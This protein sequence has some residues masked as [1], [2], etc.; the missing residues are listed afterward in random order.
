[1][2]KE[3]NKIKNPVKLTLY[4][5]HT[6]SGSL[7]LS[8]S[9]LPFSILFQSLLCWIFS[10]SLLMKYTKLHNTTINMFVCIMRDVYYIKLSFIL[11]QRNNWFNPFYSVALFIFSL[12]LFSFVCW[13]GQMKNTHTDNGWL[14]HMDVAV[15]IAPQAC[16]W[17]T[18]S[19]CLLFSS[20]FKCVCAW[21]C[22]MALYVFCA[23]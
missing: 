11:C 14:S 5:A 8:F 1:M 3:N 17:V 16:P 18:H 15:S 19:S 10:S 6:L 2:N 23:I 9:F 20:K 13:A 7:S 21:L 22:V 4:T 12:F